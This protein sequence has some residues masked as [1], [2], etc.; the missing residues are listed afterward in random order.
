VSRSR[1]VV[2]ANWKMYSTKSDINNFFKI[3]NFGSALKLSHMIFCPSIV[4]AEYVHSLILEENDSIFTVC[5]QNVSHYSLGAH[6]GAVCVEMVKELGCRYILVGH[7]ECRQDYV[8]SDQL[9]AMKVERIIGSGLIPIICVGEREDIR[10]RG[11]ALQY[12]SEQIMRSIPMKYHN[13]ELIIAYEPLW[14]IGSNQLPTNDEIETI[15]AHIKLILPKAMT[16]YGGSVHSKTSKE[17]ARISALD[18]VL[19]GRASINAAELMEII[20]HI[21][22][23]E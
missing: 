21:V 23:V 8:E 14:S 16:L 15:L 18:G 17:L 1:R 9:I 10:E 7:S 5:A 19:V 2:V 12:V 3:W 22:E 11:D 6:T 4:H 13:D 20:S